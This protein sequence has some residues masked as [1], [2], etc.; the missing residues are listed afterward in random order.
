MYDEREGNDDAH[1]PRCPA[2]VLK[3]CSHAGYGAL[4]GVAAAYCAGR[5][6]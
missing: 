4:T 1:G 3:R 6:D 5:L 2:P